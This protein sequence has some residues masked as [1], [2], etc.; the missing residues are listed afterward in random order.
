MHTPTS[1]N[2]T[3][4][5]AAFDFIGGASSPPDD[6]VVSTASEPGGTGA[7]KKFGDLFDDALTGASALVAA[8][9]PD[10]RRPNSE[11]QLPE[12]PASD[13]AAAAQAESDEPIAVSG[14]PQAP[15][16]ST[17]DQSSGDTH[18]L[19][20]DCGI[21]I[22]DAG[23]ANASNGQRPPN[24]TNE[25][26]ASLNRGAGVPNIASGESRTTSAEA[27]LRPTPPV[28]PGN[29]IP[30]TGGDSTTDSAPAPGIHQTADAAFESVARE[31]TWRSQLDNVPA[32]AAAIAAATL[33][34]SAA[35]SVGT[36]APDEV[37]V[38]A[39]LR[40]QPPAIASR[41]DQNRQ[42][43]SGQGSADPQVDPGVTG[44]VETTALGGADGGTIVDD[45]SAAS[46]RR[47]LAPQPDKASGEAARVG[48]PRQSA[49][50]SAGGPVVSPTQ[51][52]GSRLVPEPGIVSAASVQAAAAPAI[53]ARVARSVVADESNATA[54]P[55]GSASLRVSRGNAAAIPAFGSDSQLPGDVPHGRSAAPLLPD[56]ASSQGDSPEFSNWINAADEA[57]SLTP[58]E[59]GFDPAVVDA[60]GAEPSVVQ[61]VSESVRAWG[62]ALQAQGSARFAAWLTPRGL[63]Q[64][65]IELRQTAD[66]VSA[67]LS[68]TDDA[69]QSLLHQQEPGLR[70]A[71]EDSGVSVTEL[72]IFDRSAD[73]SGSSGQH[74]SPQPHEGLQTPVSDQ[75]AQPESRHAPDRS[76]LVD[77]RA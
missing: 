18:C 38:E 2:T 56:D 46:L 35:Q 63:G 73:D 29:E 16:A 19:R 42:A 15:A 71:L 37:P 22:Q 31:S 70:Q 28:R 76:S 33:Q 36:P 24:P 17:V 68:A 40:T 54:R 4:L 10:G 1:D 61:Q 60:D 57:E 53:G 55:A 21:S 51:D 43:V 26:P 47:S 44:E 8:A 67:Q 77:V 49:G 12:A 7:P 30:A 25:A 62:D 64:V 52:L 9:P 65:W 45:K 32:T 41:P 6:E 50:E 11:P 72:N 74:P 13:V 66:G 69:V 14:Q 27:D 58:A 39:A 5:L 20:I 34:F 48:V 75:A 3:A 59:L 23:V